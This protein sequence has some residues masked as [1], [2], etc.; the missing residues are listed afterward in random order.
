MG[1]EKGFGG[2]GFPEE[3]LLGEWEMAVKQGE[4]SRSCST[5]S[6]TTV[7]PTR[8]SSGWSSGDLLASNALTSLV[9][10]TLENSNTV[11]MSFPC[12]EE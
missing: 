1:T 8:G 7:S 3:V 2:Q 5:D 4:M 10:E 6:Y 9:E 11:C 12:L